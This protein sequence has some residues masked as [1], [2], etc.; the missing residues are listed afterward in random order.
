MRKAQ[1]EMIGL[2]VIVLLI[3]IG[4]FLAVSVFGNK[5]PLEMQK[6]YTNEELAT[7]FLNTLLSGKL[8]VTSGDCS[9]D[10]ENKVTLKDLLKDCVSP[11]ESCGPPIH[12]FTRCTEAKNIIRD[13]ILAKTLDTWNK[14]YRFTVTGGAEDIILPDGENKC[15]GK[16]RD[17]PAIYPLPAGGETLT[18]K[19]E[20][21]D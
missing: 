19:L 20:I 10:A 21:C 4:I 7:N 11:E 15:V 3:A 2:T 17:T 8:Y 9:I 1:M 6:H 5:D 14:P 12:T 18:L 13:E 16:E